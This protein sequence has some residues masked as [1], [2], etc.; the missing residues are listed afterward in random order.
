MQ[1]P[2]YDTNV[3]TWN[4]NCLLNASVFANARTRGRHIRDT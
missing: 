3:S 2:M 1:T 4:A